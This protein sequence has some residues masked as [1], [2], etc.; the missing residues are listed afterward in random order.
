ML[1]SRRYTVGAIVRLISAPEFDVQGSIFELE[2]NVLKHSE[3]READEYE[4]CHFSVVQLV[5]I[6]G[7]NLK[8]PREF[9]IGLHRIAPLPGSRRQGVR[10]REP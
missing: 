2:V 9:G 7:A 4:P 6:F 1:E 10:G 8:D 3:E 5:R